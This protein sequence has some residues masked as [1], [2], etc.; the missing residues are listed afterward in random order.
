M[1]EWL[2]PILFG[3][4]GLDGAALAGLFGHFL[5]LSLLAVGGAITTAPDI[6]RHVVAERGWLSD[7]QFTESIAIAQAAPGPN[8][9]F[10]AVIAYKVAGL[11]G[12]LAAMSGNLLPSTTLALAAAR[13]GERHK[14]SRAVRAFSAGMAPLTI[15]LLVATGWIL[16]APLVRLDTGAPLHSALVL[17]LLAGT[18]WAQWRYKV[19]PM[20]LIA[21]GAA[22][23]ALGWV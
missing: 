5:L 14:A 9:L 11:T 2:H 7:V 8:L 20:I 19:H 15:G 1:A 18:V 3:S 22:C 16:A 21:V 23:G 13:Y 17:A 6:H 12:V 4:L 10:I